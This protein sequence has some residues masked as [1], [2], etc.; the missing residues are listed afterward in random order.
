MSW[1]FARTPKW[2]V[3]H[4]LVVALVVSTILLGLWQLRRLDEKQ[5]QQDLVE[6][7]QQL[8]VDDVT[9]VVP[10]AA[11]GDPAVETVLYRRVRVTGT[12]MDEDTVVV[13]NR[14]YSSASGAWVLTPL[15]PSTDGP[16]VLVNRGFIGFDPAGGIVPPPA[17]GGRVTVEGIVH[18]SQERGRFGGRGP[19]VELAEM[20]RVDIEQFRSRVDYGVLP[21]YVQLTTSDPAQPPPAVGARELIPLGPPEPDEG[22]HLGYAVQWFIFGTIAGVGYLLLLRK[23]ASEHVDGDRAPATVPV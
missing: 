17:P 21:A 18:P 13:P 7:R 6:A 12:Y 3:R 5:D 11:V 1:R 16:A 23:V 4:V 2:I 19:D 14:T 15:R 20:A 22:P 8:P 9:A 10:D